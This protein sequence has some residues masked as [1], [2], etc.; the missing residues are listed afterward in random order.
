MSRMLSVIL[1]AL[2]L[3]RPSTSFAVMP[4]DSTAV[5]HEERRGLARFFSSL[6]DIDTVFIEPQH[7]KFTVM[8]QTSTLYDLMYLRF[9]DSRLRSITLSSGINFKF[10]PYF[11][12]RW[13]FLGYNFDLFYSGLSASNQADKRWELSVY[14]SALFFDLIWRST[15]NAYKIR[16]GY[17]DNGTHLHAVSGEPFDAL[18]Q[19]S[20][21]VNAFYV[22]NHRRFSMPA[23]YSQSTCQ[24]VSSGSAIV[25]LGYF[26]DKS[27]I[28]YDKFGDFFDRHY[29]GVIDADTLG[30]RDYIRY[31]TLTLSGGYGYNWVFADNWLFSVCATAGVSFKHVRNKGDEDLMRRHTFRNFTPDGTLRLGLVYNN[32]RWY[33]GSIFTLYSNNFHNSSFTSL[34]AFGKLSVYVGYNFAAFKKYRKKK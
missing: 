34:N 7:Y 22:F 5:T 23:A 31:N 25:G 21:G 10:G 33:W 11:G 9:N 20:K 17:L 6:S 28:D 8:A 24:K 12:Y 4:Q 18:K 13:A 27:G 32:M 29:P 14:S 16:S 26:Y 30:G 15:G 3:C 19:T 1:L 2:F